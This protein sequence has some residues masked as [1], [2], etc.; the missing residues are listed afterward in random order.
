M[1]QARRRADVA[2]WT[3]FV[4]CIAAMTLGAAVPHIVSSGWHWLAFPIGAGLCIWV[5]HTGNLLKREMRR[6]QTA[7]KT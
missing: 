7:R 3:T 5:E 2:Q 1:N 6:E 4:L